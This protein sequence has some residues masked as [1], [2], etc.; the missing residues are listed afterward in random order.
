M[1][2]YRR[3]QLL[4]FLGLEDSIALGVEAQGPWQCHEHGEKPD[5]AL[6]ETMVH[7]GFSS[8]AQ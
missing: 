2:R 7:Y 5:Q 8:P 4:D 6:F 3:D 1:Q